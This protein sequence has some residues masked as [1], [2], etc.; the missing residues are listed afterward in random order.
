MLEELNKAQQE[1]QE[2]DLTGQSLLDL[3]RDAV[4]DPHVVAG[5]E[6]YQLRITSAKIAKTKTPGSDRMVVKV[7]CAIEGEPF[8]KSVFINHSLPTAGDTEGTA[9]SLKHQLKKF[10][11]CFDIDPANPGRP[12]DW[13]GKTGWVILKESKSNTGEDI[14]KVSTYIVKK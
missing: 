8:A 13:K 3:H 10:M 11:Q 1:A 14:N 4:P 5:G 2:Q 7:S 9:Y 12:E 6:E